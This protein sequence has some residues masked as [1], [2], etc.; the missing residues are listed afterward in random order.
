MGHGHWHATHTPPLQDYVLSGGFVG[1]K[2]RRPGRTIHCLDQSSLYT[3][4]CNEDKKQ[5]GTPCPYLPHHTLFP[6]HHHTPLFLPHHCIFPSVY[7]APLL[8]SHPA[9]SR[10]YACHVPMLS[11]AGGLGFQDCCRDRA[12]SRRWQLAQTFPPS[13]PH[14]PPSLH[15]LHFLSFPSLLSPHT[16]LPFAPL[17]PSPALPLPSLQACVAGKEEEEATPQAV[18][19]AGGVIHSI[20]SM[21]ICPSCVLSSPPLAWLF[22]FFSLHTPLFPNHTG[23][24]YILYYLPHATHTL[25]AMPLSVCAHYILPTSTT[26]S[27]SHTSHTSF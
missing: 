7:A 25:Y 8:L 5:A 1:E 13:P 24:A 2:T 19:L 11:R 10:F 12:C 22:I 15:A 9:V 17:P 14:P 18:H 26:S 6:P 16:H 23:L 4:T 20:C 21:C 27:L 3:H